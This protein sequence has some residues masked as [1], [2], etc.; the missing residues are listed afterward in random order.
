[1]HTNLELTCHKIIVFQSWQQLQ[2][3]IAQLCTTKNDYKQREREN[4]K[5]T[6]FY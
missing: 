3:S 2:F 6:N 1:M 4:E 5:S